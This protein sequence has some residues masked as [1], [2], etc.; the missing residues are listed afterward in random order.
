[1]SSLVAE[2]GERV[3]E[4]RLAGQ[5]AARLAILFSGKA[6]SAVGL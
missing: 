4:E 6:A 1:M 3:R 5:H 2:S